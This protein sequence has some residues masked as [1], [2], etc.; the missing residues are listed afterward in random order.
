LYRAELLDK[1]FGKNC[2]WQ[3]YQNKGNLRN[4]EEFE[5]V[6]VCGLRLSWK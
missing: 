6:S 3:Q 2:F 4:A 1:E 5:V